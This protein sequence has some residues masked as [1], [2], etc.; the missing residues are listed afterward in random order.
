MSSR[1]L[2]IDDTRLASQLDVVYSWRGTRRV[3]DVRFGNVRDEQDITAGALRPSGDDWCLVI[4]FPFDADDYRPADDLARLE[5]WRT[6][7]P[8]GA[9]T[10]VWIPSFFSARSQA[11]L[12]RLVIHE[13]V[14]A[15]D[16]FRRYA[17]H[18]SEAEQAS[19]RRRWRRSA[20]RCGRACGSR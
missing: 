5:Q 13:H 20:T 6:A 10:I 17:A 8:D 18:L 9:R 4:D 12:G 2:E 11:D 16:G 19:A 15:G 3:A 14:L 7:N 1:M